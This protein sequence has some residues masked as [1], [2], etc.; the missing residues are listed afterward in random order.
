MK[1]RLI[2]LL[3]ALSLALTFA[4]CDGRRGR[5]AATGSDLTQKQID[6][7]VEKA[8]KEAKAQSK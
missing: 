8:E 1:K 7:L 3:L 2:S 6:R 5:G 4:A